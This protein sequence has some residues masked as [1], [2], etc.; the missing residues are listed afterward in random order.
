MATGTNIS[1]KAV[2]PLPVILQ[3]TI[4]TAESG[5]TVKFGFVHIQAHTLLYAPFITAFETRPKFHNASLDAF[6]I[7]IWYAMADC[8]AP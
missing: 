7:E 8:Q 6:F 2:K 3:V 4:P 1:L 5:R